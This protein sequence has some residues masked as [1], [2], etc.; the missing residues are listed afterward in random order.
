MWSPFVRK[1]TFPQIAPEG[2]DMS[3]GMQDPGVIPGAGAQLPGRTYPITGAPGEQVQPMP[4]G[5]ASRQPVQMPAPRQYLPS[6][7][8]FGMP[9]GS[10]SGNMFDRQ[11]QNGFLRRYAPPQLQGSRLQNMGGFMGFTGPQFAPVSTSQFRQLQDV[12]RQLTAA[13]PPA[14]PYQGSWFNSDSNGGA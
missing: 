6:W 4:G 5:F 13:P 2:P 11:M 1:N 10:F 7:S 12:I 14:E 3:A 8:P 9:L